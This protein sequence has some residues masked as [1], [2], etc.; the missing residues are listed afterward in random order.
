MRGFYTLAD[1]LSSGHAVFTGVLEPSSSPLR[2]FSLTGIFFI[3]MSPRFS[4]FR[5]LC[6]FSSNFANSHDRACQCYGKIGVVSHKRAR[7][8]RH[9]SGQCFRKYYNVL[10][11]YN[12]INRYMRWE[13]YNQS[14]LYARLEWWSF[15]RFNKIS[16]L[17]QVHPWLNINVCKPQLYSTI[18]VDCSQNTHLITTKC[19]WSD[20]A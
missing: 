2:A 14:R 1:Y 3:S 4:A 17:F 19:G 9:C 10:I 8:I 20:F 13:V 16:A 7:I 11:F 15:T 12:V 18:V 6:R 5:P